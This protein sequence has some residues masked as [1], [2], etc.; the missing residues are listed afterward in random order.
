MDVLSFDKL[1]MLW[2]WTAART[3]S[4]WKSGMMNL[5]SLTC[6]GSWKWLEEADSTWDKQRTQGLG[7]QACSPTCV[8]LVIP[9]SRS[10]LV[11]AFRLIIRIEGTD[12]IVKWHLVGIITNGN[13]YPSQGHICLIMQFWRK[14]TSATLMRRGAGRRNFA[15]T[16]ALE[17]NVYYARNLR[18]WQAQRRFSSH[19]RT[20]RVIGKGR[21]GF[22]ALHQPLPRNTLW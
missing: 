1:R 4:I 20:S 21:R 11:M 3:S 18:A 17:H 7:N 19:S 22:T 5:E 10:I 8:S 12:H 16:T 14:Q 2:T 9:R 13:F 15:S 6:R